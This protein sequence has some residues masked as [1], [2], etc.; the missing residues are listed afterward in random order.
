MGR[1]HRCTAP[2]SAG[3]VYPSAPLSRSQTGCASLPP[4]PAVLRLEYGVYGPRGL[5]GDQ[6]VSSHQFEEVSAGRL[7]SPPIYC[8]ILIAHVKGRS[9]AR[10]S[11][12]TSSQT[13]SQ[14]G[15]EGRDGE[16][17]SAFCLE[18]DWTM[19]SWVFGRISLV[20]KVSLSSQA[21]PEFNTPRSENNTNFRRNAQEKAATRGG[22]R[23]ALQFSV[24]FPYSQR[25]QQLAA[26]AS[27]SRQ[28]PL[29]RGRWGGWSQG[30]TPRT[31]TSRTR[32]WRT[33]STS[34]TICPRPTTAARTWRRIG[35]SRTDGR[36]NSLVWR[37]RRRR[38]ATEGCVN[39][40]AHTRTCTRAFCGWCLLPTAAEQ[41][42]PARH[43]HRM[44]RCRE[45]WGAPCTS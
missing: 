11:S 42:A 37:G 17:G 1:P 21:G 35:R 43:A 29:L 34:S 2:S 24:S 8:K 4:L 39:P 27:I 19:N 32:R 14:S 5:E 26:G 16:P 22:Q 20:S 25:I 7:K 18:C 28:W 13:D 45:L 23:G 30:R 12:M 36:A 6:T 15:C 40:A 33:T 31:R 44:Q 10:I 3:F 41:C 38:P 9:T